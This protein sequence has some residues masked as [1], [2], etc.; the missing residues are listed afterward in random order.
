V[1]LTVQDAGC[2]MDEK[3]RKSIFEPFFTTKQPGKGTGLGLATVYGIVQQSGGAIGVTSAPGAGAT[4]TIY[5]PLE[6]A[7]VDRPVRAG[8]AEPRRDHSE[9][10]LVVEDDRTVRELV[11]RSLGRRGYHVLCAG[12]CDEALRIANEHPGTIDLVLT[13]VIMPQMHGPQLANELRQRRPNTKV[14]YVSGYS[15][16]EI[17]DQGVLSPE[18]HFL[19]KPFTPDTLARKVRAVLDQDVAAAMASA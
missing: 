16:T 6:N 17:A 18:V 7:P 2:G 12:R 11:C 5:L 9:T 10:V 8:P 4:F 14:L 13:D 19:Q 15:D 3:T 1:T